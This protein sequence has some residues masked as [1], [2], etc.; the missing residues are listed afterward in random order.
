M[1][2][3]DV[4]KIGRNYMP[5]V[6]S[7]NCNISGADTSLPTHKLACNYPEYQLKLKQDI[8][9]YCTNIATRDMNFWVGSQ[10]I[11]PHG[12]E[13]LLGTLS[14]Q[15]HSDGWKCSTIEFDE[16]F[17]SWIV[18]RKVFNPIEKIWALLSR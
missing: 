14:E 15:K 2:I 8:L 13:V 7:N 16:T 18:I 10:G 12:I 11:L 1:S 4:V 9:N 5:N 3:P 6:V 17:Y